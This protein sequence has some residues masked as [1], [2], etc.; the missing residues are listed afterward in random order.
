GVISSRSPASG[1]PKNRRR[2]Q[3]RA[4]AGRDADDFA[5]GEFQRG[6]DFHQDG[7]TV[8]KDFLGGGAEGEQGGIDRLELSTDLENVR[9]RGVALR[10][11]GGDVDHVAGLKLRV[12][13][14]PD[15]RYNAVRLE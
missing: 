7:Q 14:L 15:V 10:S 3:L 6:W 2:S 1:A 4:V 8:L 11:A 13:R 5:G 9:C 12:E